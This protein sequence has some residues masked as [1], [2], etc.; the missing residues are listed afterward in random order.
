MGDK[1]QRQFLAS[2]R[3]P[4]IN[5]LCLEMQSI[6]TNL[7]LFLAETHGYS[8]QEISRIMRGV[9]YDDLNTDVKAAP[10]S[11][12]EPEAQIE[13]HTKPQ[14]A[15]SDNLEQLKREDEMIRRSMTFELEWCVAQI[16]HGNKPYTD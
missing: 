4:Q 15:S 9:K 8:E 12:R 3:R 5:Q 6:I 11:G 14:P 2:L 10:P 13:Q 7:K 16:E 1:E